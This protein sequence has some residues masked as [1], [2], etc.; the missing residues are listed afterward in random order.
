MGLWICGGNTSLTVATGKHDINVN[1][2]MKCYIV[3]TVREGIIILSGNIYLHNILHS[4][5]N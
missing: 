2:H 5:S 1:E 4:I 3:S